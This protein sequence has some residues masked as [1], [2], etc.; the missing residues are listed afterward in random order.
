LTSRSCR[1]L[2]YRAATAATNAGGSPPASPD[3]MIKLLNLTH[4]TAET[5]AAITQR[6]V[7]GGR[8][9]PDH[10]IHDGSR[11]G[12]QAPLLTRG[13]GRNSGREGGWKEAR[14]R[15]AS[16]FRLDASI[17]ARFR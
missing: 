8:M 9:T 7:S 5:L 16:C 4:T 12:R 14:E 1:R 13:I 15:L 11:T 17:V 10:S 6:E 2:S 3:T